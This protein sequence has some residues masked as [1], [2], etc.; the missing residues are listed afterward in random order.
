LNYYLK[1]LEAMLDAER[2]QIALWPLWRTWT[3]ALN[4][5]S[6]RSPHLTAWQAAG[7]NLGMLG[8]AFQERLTALDAF[9]DLIDENLEVWAKENGA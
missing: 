4:L 1:A 2:F 9:L 5:L 8:K 6:P 7:E 3:H